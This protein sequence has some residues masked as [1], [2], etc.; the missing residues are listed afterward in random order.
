MMP[1]KNGREERRKEK[2]NKNC[3]KN[4]REGERHR[5]N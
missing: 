4:A 1:E 5:R 3:Q 2:Q